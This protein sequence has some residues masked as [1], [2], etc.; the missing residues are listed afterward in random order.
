MVTIKGTERSVKVAR[1]LI[2]EALSTP[3]K[4]IDVPPITQEV[5]SQSQDTSQPSSQ[6]VQTISQSSINPWNQSQPPASVWGQKR[7][8]DV[9]PPSLS[10]LRNA[11]QEEKQRRVGVTM[12]MR[13]ISLP[14]HIHNYELQLK[15]SIN[16][17]NDVRNSNKDDNSE[18]DC[19]MTIA[20][21]TS[22]TSTTV[23]SSLTVHTGAIKSSPSPP[24]PPPPP[25]PSSSPPPRHSS[26][27]S[28]SLSRVN[29]KD[30]DEEDVPKHKRSLS[31]PAVTPSTINQISPTGS[32]THSTSPL[33][34]PSVTTS[35]YSP[36]MPSILSPSENESTTSSSTP[37]S[38]QPL[39]S[40][41]GGV[42][43]PTDPL[44]A[45]SRTKTVGIVTPTQVKP[46]QVK[47]IFNIIINNVHV[48]ICS[49]KLNFGL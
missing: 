47:Y 8:S 25:F 41:V 27:T 3:S 9:V 37:S 18:H 20:L 7:H 40:Q 23:S 12:A 24:P 19:P 10:L 21:T 13:R 36:T 34:L 38:I 46:V 17:S 45:I 33:N 42:A 22:S 6:T 48:I 49:W 32:L 5:Q 44:V 16:L 26:L 4:D 31:E 35:R 29:E 43:V 15:E 2:E 1:E 14:V 11:G 39:N 30:E 28:G